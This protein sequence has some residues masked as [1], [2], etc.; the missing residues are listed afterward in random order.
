MNF[1]F[2]IQIYFT[3]ATTS[4]LSNTAAIECH[5]HH[6]TPLSTATIENKVMVL[7]DGSQGNKQE[8]RKIVSFRFIIL[9]DASIGLIFVLEQRFCESQFFLKYFAATVSK[10]IFSPHPSQE[11]SHREWEISRSFFVCTRCSVGLRRS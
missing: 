9:T 8:S 3:T 4:L 11:I 1:S 2:T 5:H 6:Q 10:S 7:K